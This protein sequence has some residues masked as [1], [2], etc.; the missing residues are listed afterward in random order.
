MRTKNYDKVIVGG[1]AEGE[2]MALEMG[3]PKRDESCIIETGIGEVSGYQ[4][5]NGDH[6]NPETMIIMFLDSMSEAESLGIVDEVSAWN[7]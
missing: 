1:L 6:E 4:F 3:Y 2:Y 7:S 5:W